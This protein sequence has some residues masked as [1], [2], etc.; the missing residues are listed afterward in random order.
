MAQSLAKI[1]V[2]L[3]Y[4]TKERRPL[5]HDGS[6]DELHR[7]TATVLKDIESPA[8]LINSVEDHIHI[9]LSLSR[10]AAISDVVEKVKKETSKW[11]KRRDQSLSDF[12]WQSGY[13]VFSVALSNLP[14]VRSYIAGQREHHLKVSFQD[15]FR[16][17]LKK[18]EIPY[19]ERYV[20]D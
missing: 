5:I 12:Y 13:G 11:I 6:R 14:S 16:V 8:L 2:H 1:L 9:L 19:D 7:Y 4:S 20:W 15:E 17:F 10:R 3:I 18:Y